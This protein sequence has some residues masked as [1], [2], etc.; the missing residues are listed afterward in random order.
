MTQ[1]QL[2][3]QALTNTNY[4]WTLT[5]DN[6]T[7]ASGNADLLPNQLVT[8]RKQQVTLGELSDSLLNFEANKKWLWQTFDEAGQLQLGAYL[9][10]QTLA[11]CNDNLPAS[12]QAVQLV[13]I[14][15]D[16]FIQR[17]PWNLLSRDNKTFLIADD[18][19]INIAT[20]A[21]R[22]RV[23]FSAA[24][25]QQAL[26]SINPL[27]ASDE[28]LAVSET[29]QSFLQQLKQQQWDVVYFYGHGVADSE[30]GKLMFAD[31]QGKPKAIA[32]V[33]IAH[34]LRDKSPDVVYLNAC[35]TANGSIAG[36]VAQ[37]SD[38]IPA[39]ILNRTNA[40]MVEAREQGLSFLI[41]ILL[42]NISP[43][44]AISR[45]YLTETSGMSSTAWMTPILFQHYAE[46][47]FPQSAI[48]PFTSDPN[49][50]L[51]LDRVPQFSQV[52]YHISTMIQQRHPLTLACFWHGVKGQGVERFHERLPVELRDLELN[53]RL[54]SFSF[55]WPVHFVDRYVAFEQ[56]THL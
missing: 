25:I 54:E 52:H 27:F 55:Q 48:A 40:F 51:K 37:L 22:H 7:L 46:W 17:L 5:S 1:F 56:I 45:A 20:H 31:D 35:Q 15:D 43:Q 3:I 13:V 18:W 34:L 29:W 44:L 39:L 14:S 26:S 30:T 2:S 16:A 38:S 24:A 4:H 33:K 19:T 21:S 36:A 49:W 6:K 42:N 28:Y 47:V 50:R 53:V 41:D 23:Q 11:Y 9:Y 32:M 10:Q 8:L 12:G